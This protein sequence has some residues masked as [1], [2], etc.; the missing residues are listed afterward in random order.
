MKIKPVSTQRF[1]GGSKM[2]KSLTMHASTFVSAATQAL[3]AFIIFFLASGTLVAQERI[4]VIQSEPLPSLLL[5]FGTGINH[6]TGLFGLGIEAPI[7]S[8]FSLFANAGIGSWGTKFGGGLRYYRHPDLYGSA[9]AL[10]YSQSSGLKDFEYE[11]EVENPKR[12]MDV[13]LDLEPVGCLAFDYSY[14]LKM[15][16]KSKISLH[17]GYALD[18]GEGDKYVLRT[19]GVELSSN[20]KDLLWLIQPGGLLLGIN[21]MFGL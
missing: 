19:P 12:D 4:K 2:K 8:S 11:L 3:I 18:L 5:G 14:N 17:A 10:G 6:Y 9:F 21:L 16:H 7:F 15:G 20:S 1:W 13:L